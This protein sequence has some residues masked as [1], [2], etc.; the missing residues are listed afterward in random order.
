MGLMEQTAAIFDLAGTPELTLGGDFEAVVRLYWPK[1][2][3]FAFASLGDRDAAESIAQDCFWKAYESRERFRNE[4]SLNGWLMRIAVNLIRDH[5]R[6]RRLQFWRRT[7]QFGSAPEQFAERWAD[8]R[9]S[10]EQDA[11]LKERL[12]AVWRAASELSE[13]QRTVFLLRFVEEMEILEIARA[14]GLR[15]GTVKAHLFRAVQSVRERIEA[16][17]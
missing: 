12:T 7:T 11:L 10:P 3:R 6:N 13:R 4:C 16:G 9:L 2:F 15:E 5:G 14:T 8:A 17:K 1:I